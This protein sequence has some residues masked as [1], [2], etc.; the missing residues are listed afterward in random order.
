MILYNISFKKKLNALYIFPLDLPKAS[1]TYILLMTLDIIPYV[2]LYVNFNVVLK[3]L[4]NLLPKRWMSGYHG[5][6]KT[7]EAI[8]MVS[9][10][11]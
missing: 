6:T 9:P 3:I 11:Y 4:W 2:Q 5:D 8:C 10:L 1:N 7:T